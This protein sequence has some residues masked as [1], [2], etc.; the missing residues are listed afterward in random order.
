LA[1]LGEPATAV[2]WLTQATTTGFSC[3]PWFE[4][5]PLLD[6]IRGDAGFAAFARELRRSWDA[7]RAKYAECVSGSRRP[8][9][10]C[11]ETRETPSR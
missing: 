4:R 2:R 3:Y 1:Q 7:A 6:P 10:R 9:I 11:A 5:D 8:E